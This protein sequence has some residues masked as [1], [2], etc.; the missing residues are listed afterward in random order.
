MDLQITHSLVL[1]AFFELAQ[2]DRVVTRPRL[3]A[4]T[5]LLPDQ[6]RD[7]LGDLQTAGWVDADALRLTLPGLAVA[8]AVRGRARELRT[9]RVLAA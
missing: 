2:Q 3:S 8:V 4:F 6:V 5:G 9:T 7:T 1:A